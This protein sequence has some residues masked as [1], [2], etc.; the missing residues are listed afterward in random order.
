MIVR[1]R[2]ADLPTAGFWH[3]RRVPTAD[4]WPL[5]L[6]GA[7]DAEMLHRH[8]VF[9]LVELYLGAV[10]LGHAALGI[11]KSFTN[12]FTRTSSSL[13]VHCTHTVHSASAH[14]Q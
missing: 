14:Y 1:S 4:C 3:G 7:A 8:K 10:M 2:P 12:R 13:A 5:L 9:L 11:Y 6:H